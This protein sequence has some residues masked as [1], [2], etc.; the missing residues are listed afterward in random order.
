[1][2]ASVAGLSPARVKRGQASEEG[3]GEGRS[4]SSMGDRLYFAATEQGS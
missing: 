3:H 2:E 4:C 1:M